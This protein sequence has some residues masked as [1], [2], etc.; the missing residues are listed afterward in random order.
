MR[1]SYSKVET[2]VK[3]PYKYNIKYNA[4]LVAFPNLDPTNPLILGT[5]LHMGIEQDTETA[6]QWYCDQFPLIDDKHVEEIIKLET[7]I[8]KARAILPLGEHERKIEVMEPMHFIGFMD[9]L[10]PIND[11]E[12][13]LYD[14]KYSNNMDRYLEESAQ[15]H[16]YKHFFEQMNWKSIRR[17]FFVFAPKVSIRLKKSE[18]V[19]D[20]RIRLRNE[21][22]S[23]EVQVREVEYSKVATNW[24]MNTAKIIPLVSEYPK[25]STKLCDFCEFQRFCESDGA[26][27][28]EIDWQTSYENGVNSMALPKN[29][30]TPVSKTE[31]KKIWFYGTSFSGKTWIMNQ[32]PNVL[33]LSTDGNYKNLPGGIPPHIDLV[34]QV[35]TEG[36]LTKRKYAWEVF[37]DAIT[38]LETDTDSGFETIALDVI[39]QAREMC[40]TWFFATH[41][42]EHEA[43]AGYGK[44]FGMV[45]KE[46]NDVMARFWGLATKYNVL[47]ASHLDDS[48]DITKK[49]GD[50]VTK[51]MPANSKRYLTDLTS[52]VDMVIRLTG[53]N[54][55]YTMSFKNNEYVHGGGRLGVNGLPDMPTTYENICKIYDEYNAKL[56]GGDSKP[57]EA[58][59]PEVKPVEPVTVES[60]TEADTTEAVEEKPVRKRRSRRVEE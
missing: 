34:D 33:F 41:G 13:D 20:F 49:S 60:P 58:P 59:T 31:K 57:V 10:V 36:R 3:C 52:R 42:I 28:Y 38:D 9:L 30:R 39:N 23:K 19:E 53:E 48:S 27:D 56:T 50:K 47:G 12:Y 16:V 18:T 45:D 5:A 29:V 14:F 35:W 26:D 7:V 44:G 37:K 46:F 54:D 32:F 24:F 2:F 11:T 22:A 6:I 8:E 51:I 21:L 25:N 40:R 55:V 15:L 17:M 4:G 1:M 43:D